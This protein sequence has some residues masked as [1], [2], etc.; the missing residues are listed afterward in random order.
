MFILDFKRLT[1]RFQFGPNN[2]AKAAATPIKVGICALWQSCTCSRQK[3]FWKVNLT[4][5]SAVWSNLKEHRWRELWT[6][7]SSVVN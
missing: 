5:R 6:G 1:I 3:Y 4:H 7:I 2:F